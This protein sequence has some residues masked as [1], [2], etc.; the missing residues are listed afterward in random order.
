MISLLTELESAKVCGHR[1]DVVQRSF[2]GKTV[3]LTKKGGNPWETK[4][5]K[6]IKIKLKNKKPTN[7]QKKTRR[8]SRGF[9]FA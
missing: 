6:K 7:R 2:H 3:N 4:A 9:F 8:N 5:E 1:I